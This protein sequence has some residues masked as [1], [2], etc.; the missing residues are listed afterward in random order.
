MSSE[1]SKWVSK[2]W[3]NEADEF[4]ILGISHD[5]R[6]LKEGDVY[7]AIRGE[8][9]DGH[10]FVGQAFEKGAAGIIVEKLCPSIQKPQLVVS[11]TRTA[12]WQMAAGA[13][14]GWAGTVIGVTGSAGKTTVKEMVASVLSQKGTVSKTI[15]NWNN[16]IGLPLSMI[17]ADRNSDFFVFELGMSHP[18]EIQLLAGLLE[19]DWAL[20]TNIGKAHIGS[21]QS[22]EKIADEKASIFEH[23]K[24]GLLDRDSEWFDRMKRRFDGAVTALT[25]R[26]IH[27]FQPGEHMMQNA[28][29]AATLGLAL[30]LTLE[31]VQAGLD[32]FEPAPMRW[33]VSLY[34]GITLINDAYN[35]NPLSMRAAVSTFAEMPCSGR[36]FLVLGGML[37]LGDSELEEHQLLGEFIEPF[38]FDRVIT[39]GSLGGLI[40]CGGAC[41]TTKE[42]AADI[43]SKELC[44]GDMVLL[45]A[46]RGARLETILEE[47]KKTI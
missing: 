13:R 37:E 21:F 45:K 24:H 43:L 38:R 10:D 1:I 41:G 26:P 6:T 46:S 3:K 19:P 5:T 23:S 2:P 28:R 16:E 31:E 4:P 39:I 14:A 22:L 47:L 8:N 32:A 44:E 35:A 11:D 20:V 29:F 30:G 34:K 36:K 27:V 9:H 17:A 40:A 42:E 15:G 12:L 7:I 33:A 18:G 25:D